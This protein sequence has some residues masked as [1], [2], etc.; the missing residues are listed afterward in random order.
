MS[1]NIGHSCWSGGWRHWKKVL[2]VLDA[3]NSSVN[4]DLVENYH[5]IPPKGSP[6]NY[7]KIKL[8]ERLWT[9]ITEQK[10]VKTT[11]TWVLKLPAAVKIYIN[12][13][14]CPYYKKLWSKCSTSWDA[15]WIL[16]FWVSN[17]SIRVKL[18]N[19]NVSIIT[20]DCDLEKLFPGDP[21]IADTN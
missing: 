20:H 9:G 11:E 2:E 18:M 7:F 19:K 10:K 1:R 8:P 17:G 15:K 4:T 6:K 21:L 16:S 12:Q 3:I 13:N 14:L 5:C